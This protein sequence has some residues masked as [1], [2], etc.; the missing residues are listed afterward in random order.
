MCLLSKLLIKCPMSYLHFK[1]QVTP[2]LICLWLRFLDS[3]SL[4]SSLVKIHGLPLR[5]CIAHP[6]PYCLPNVTSSYTKLNL[7]V[8]Y[9]Y[10]PLVKHYGFPWK[11]VIE[12][13]YYLCQSL[14]LETLKAYFF[15]FYSYLKGNPCLLG[16][17]NRP[18]WY[19]VCTGCCFVFRDSVF[20]LNLLI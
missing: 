11:S 8:K 15:M 19:T 6:G 13:N 5:C 7:C 10:L 4:G 12:G 20:R 9:Q 17:N 3:L 16:K 2:M 1:R 14:G 18:L